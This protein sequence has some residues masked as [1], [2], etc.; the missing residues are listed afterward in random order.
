MP[1]ISFVVPVYTAEKYL[2]PCLDSI[3][4]Q[5]NNNELILVDDGS[6]DHFNQGTVQYVSDYVQA[7]EKLAW[8]H[9]DPILS[10]FD[11]DTYSRRLRRFDRILRQI[12][13]LPMN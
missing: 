3:V 2:R 4:C 5:L 1:L 6:T 8:I 10:G 11:Y 9:T 13:C 12:R 7:K